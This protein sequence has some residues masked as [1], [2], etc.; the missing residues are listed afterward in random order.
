MT[1]PEGLDAKDWGRA[2]LMILVPADWAGNLAD[3]ETIKDEG[4]FAPFRLLTEMARFPH[5]N[6]TFLGPGHTVQNGKPVAPGS[7]MDSAMIHWSVA[8]PSDQ[9]RLTL[10]N[11]DKINFYAVYPI[12]ASER[13]VAVD[14]NTDV[15]FE[16]MLET[17][18]GL[19]FNPKRPPLFPAN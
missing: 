10:D 3:P 6:T 5:N 19:V 8:L 4:N 16:K 11:G 17:G 15:V 14:Q 1:L 2:E 7:P 18:A 12:H 9:L 13:Q